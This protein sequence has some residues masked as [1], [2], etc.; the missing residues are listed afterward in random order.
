MTRCRHNLA[1][2]GQWCHVVCI[3]RLPQSWS[4][5]EAEQRIP[6]CCQVKDPS[7]R[8]MLRDGMLRSDWYKPTQMRFASTVGAV[9]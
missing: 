1:G 4:E 3:E 8:P 6:T 7:Q 5:V 9:G 2:I